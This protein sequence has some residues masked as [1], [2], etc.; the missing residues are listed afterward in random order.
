MF[1]AL[2]VIPASSYA[3]PAC[4]PANDGEEVVEDLITYKCGWDGFRW[5]WEPIGFPGIS[6]FPNA[7]ESSGSS[8]L[9]VAPSVTLSAPAPSAWRVVADV[10]AA[11]YSESKQCSAGSTVCTLDGGSF[12]LPP[13]QYYGMNIN[14]FVGSTMVFAASPS[15]YVS[16]D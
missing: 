3:L 10:P 16:C 6:Y 12:L 14:T 2:L 11:S 7:N 15:A 8:Y 4:G 13:F 1:G 5:D 9:N